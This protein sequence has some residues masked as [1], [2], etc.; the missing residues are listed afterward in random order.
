[1]SVSRPSSDTLGQR[2]ADRPYGCYETGVP[3]APIRELFADCNVTR[4]H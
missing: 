1:M 3:C 4:A 2:A